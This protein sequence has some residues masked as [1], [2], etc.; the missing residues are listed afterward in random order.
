M[1]KLLSI[2]LAVTL[3]VLLA[4]SAL[5]SGGA[6]IYAV[7]FRENPTTGYT[8]TYSSSD[9]AVLAVDDQGYAEPENA[10]LGAG[11]EHTWVISGVGQ[12]EAT[13][14][15]TYAQSWESNPSDPVIVYSFTV[16]EDLIPQL[17]SVTGLPEKY[18]P[19]YAVVQLTSNPTTGYMWT[20]SIDADEVLATGSDFFTA[21]ANTAGL[22]GAGGVQTFIFGASGAGEA[23]VTFQYAR[24]FEASEAPAATV[25][26]TFTVDD[27]LNVTQ[28]AVGGDYN[29]Y[30]VDVNVTATAE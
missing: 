11:S 19:E 21:D 22:V 9:D 5:A 24:S 27:Q 18:M 10:M 12:G 3:F 26:V 6:T 2:S 29:E 13:V 7:V 14:T 25:T 23:T 1:K 16:G 17:K 4:G 15:F 28:T 8:W 30:A 20:S